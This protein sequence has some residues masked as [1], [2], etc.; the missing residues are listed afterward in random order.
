MF[1]FGLKCLNLSATR[2]SMVVKA[3]AR[4]KKEP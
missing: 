1:E 3:L 2:K 4:K